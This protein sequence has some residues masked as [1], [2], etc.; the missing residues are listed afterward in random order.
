MP[1]RADFYIESTW[2]GSIT[3]DGYPDNPEL[4]KLD[5]TRQC[6]F[7]ER[8]SELLKQRRDSTLPSEGWPWPWDDS[9]L[10]GYAYVWHNDKV[11]VSEGM[12]PLVLVPFTE[13]LAMSENEVDDYYDSWEEHPSAIPWS[14][15]NMSQHR[16][17]HDKMMRK[18]G[19]II[20]GN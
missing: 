2:L 1:T 7:E 12:E 16:M 18:S 6:V 14:F 10:T 5:T 11:W 4:Q 15:P 9:T 3:F 8:I 20:I 13:L 17:H 19:L